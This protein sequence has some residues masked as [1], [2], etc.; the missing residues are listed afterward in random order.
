MKITVYNV[1]GGVGKTRI[2]LNLALT[3]DFGVVTNEIYYP[4]LKKV[5]EKKSLTVLEKNDVLEIDPE[6]H[7]DFN[8]I[9][10]F[11]GFMDNRIV[12][13]LKHSDWV[14]VPTINEFDDITATVNIIQE[15]EEINKNI[16][17]IANKTQ[18][19]D[20]EHVQSAI[21]KFYD[22]PV[23]Q[24]KYSR[25]LPNI[26]NERKSVKAMAEESGL[27]AYSYKALTE[28]FDQLINFITKEVKNG[29]EV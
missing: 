5:L 22:Y 3:M 11:G 19:G 6:K 14:L 21:A 1:K 4:T 28:Q 25:A 20:F 9:F 15:I 12:A 8:V 17:V 16:V 24:I 26:T 2:A 13:A 27:K 7:K 23:F 10:D 29:T 18:K